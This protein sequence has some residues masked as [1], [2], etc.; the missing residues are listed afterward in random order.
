MALRG[1]SFF[2]GCF[3]GEI[4][5]GPGGGLFYLRS[6]VRFA[7]QGAGRTFCG[8]DLD[9]FAAGMILC[10]C[11]GGGGGAL[12]RFFYACY[13]FGA[14]VCFQIFDIF[15]PGHVLSWIPN[16]QQKAPVGASRLKKSTW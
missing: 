13:G 6:G 4:E 14:A 5:K 1:H 8:I 15:F 9:V 2:V 10:I 11:I 3:S 12:L 16:K 7:V